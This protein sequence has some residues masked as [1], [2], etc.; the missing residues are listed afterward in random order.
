MLEKLELKILPVIQVFIFTILIWLTSRFT[1][2]I[3]SY[4][5]ERVLISIFLL[6]LGSWIGASGVVAFH[7]ANTT[8]DPTEPGK[9]SF[10][11]KTG[12]YKI[13]RNPM[14]V[15]LLLFLL[16]ACVFLGSVISLIFCFF[17]VLSMNRFQILPEERFLLKNFGKEYEDYKR[18]V[19]RW[20]LF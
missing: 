8:V 4:K 1:P 12:I 6:S 11:V 5:W 7:R 10:L 2:V 17:F 15:G 3:S 14:Y 18:N 13:T 9:A 19:S 20:L 16:S